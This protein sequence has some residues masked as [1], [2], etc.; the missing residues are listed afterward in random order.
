MGKFKYESY[1]Y[2]VIGI[3]KTLKATWSKTTL[4]DIRAFHNIDAERELTAILSEQIAAEVDREIE[5][6]SRGPVNVPTYISN[7]AEFFNVYSNSL[8]RS[9]AKVM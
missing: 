3:N 1:D 9:K 7:E 8:A 2:S 4:G 6:L 5:M